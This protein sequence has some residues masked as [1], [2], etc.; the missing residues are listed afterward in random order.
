MNAR[1][2]RRL[3]FPVILLA[4]VTVSLALNHGKRDDVPPEVFAELP[5]RVPAGLP[6]K[7][8]LSA[9]EPVIYQA[10][11]ADT[12]IEEVTQDLEFELLAVAGESAVEVKA[13]DGAENESSYQF[14][15]FGIPELKPVVTTLSETLP[16]EPLSVAVSWPQAEVKIDTLSVSLNGEAIPV[17]K[18]ANNALSLATVP[19]GS[20]PATQL[21]EVSLVDQYGREAR[22]EK[23][24]RVLKDPRLIEELNISAGTFSVVTQENAALEAK[25]LADAFADTTYKQTPLWLE[26][27][28]LPLEGRTTSAFGD[29]RR[30]VSGGPVS[31]HKGEDIAAPTGTV[32]PATN[33]GRVV[34]AAFLPIKG[35]TTI[36]DHGGGVFSLY[37]HQSKINVAA[38]DEVKRGQIIGEVGSTGLST[39]PHLHWEMRIAGV[40]TN[41]MGWVGKTVP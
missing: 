12:V 29:P 2:L 15:V 17:L 30:Y 20:P 34:A 18:D 14:A 4:A 3:I 25:I 10:R 33:D 21:I 35:G 39:G 19:L 11:Y 6:F 32:I 22:L 38:G 37:L 13:K 24:L 5:A 31:Y 9:N 36:I 8:R 7:V 27:F 1:L 26:P 41:P 40:P 23:E 28:L 16:G